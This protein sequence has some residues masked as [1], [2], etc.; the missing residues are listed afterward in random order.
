MFSKDRSGT[1]GATRP[2]PGVVIT[3]VALVVLSGVLFVLVW[4]ATVFSGPRP[5]K[6][7]RKY[8]EVRKQFRIIHGQ[9]A[10]CLP[11]QIPAGATGIT[12]YA[13]LD[14]MLQA[15]PHLT[16]EYRLPN[17][18]AEAELARLRALSPVSETTTIDG[19]INFD[20][21]PDTWPHIHV[22]V[23]SA[24]RTFEYNIQDD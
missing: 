24:E 20:F 9:L 18:A 17:D 8:P 5:V 13:S 1:A 11:L 4:G 19:V 3:L 21:S 12:F 7:V 6:D 23:N 15:E 16:L 14:D 10:R 2:R 22:T